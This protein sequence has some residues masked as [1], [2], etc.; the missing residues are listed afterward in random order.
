[1]KKP[2]L[3]LC[4]FPATGWAVTIRIAASSIVENAMLAVDVSHR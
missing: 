2:L 1:M 3:A 4:F